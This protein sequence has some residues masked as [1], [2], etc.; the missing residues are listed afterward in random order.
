MKQL[1]ISLLLALFLYGCNSE[2]TQNDYAEDP[3]RKDQW[4]ISGVNSE[5]DIEHINL[6]QTHYSGR[7][8]LIS[9]VDNG[10]DISH[11][12]LKPNIGIGNYSYLPKEYNFEEKS[13][14]GTACAGIIA[15]VEGNGKGIRGIA[16]SA[17]II[18]FNALRLATISNLADAL[19]REKS[20]VWISNNS[21]G[22]I[23]SWGEP[24]ALKKLMEDALIEGVSKGRDGKGI[25]YVF[26]AGNG[27][28]IVND[29]PIDNVNYSGLVNN[30][31]TVPVC[32][33]DEYG[34]RAFYSEKGA[35]LI[36]CAPSKGSVSGRGITTTDVQGKYGYN[37][38]YFKEDYLDQNYTKNF[39]G[40]S[41]SAPIVSGVIGLI[42]EA[43][44]QLT[45]RDI[46][47]V[48]AKSAKKNDARD[49]DWRINSAGYH[50]NHKYGFGLVDTD[51][52]IR[53]ALQHKLLEKEQ[54]FE[55][56][57]NVSMI[58]PDGSNEGISDEISVDND[59]KI[60][61]IDVV[62]DASDH[63]NLGE[64]DVILTSPTGTIS[65]L[66]EQHNTLFDVFV[67]NHWRFGTMRHLGEQAKGIW[68]INVIDKKSGNT[69]TFFKWKLKFY[70]NN[71]DA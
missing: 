6:N 50:V 12:D 70:G 54:I 15:A 14:H 37:P 38:L 9:L 19:I 36:V 67:Y 61:F 10:I 22:D 34:K 45:W 46:R 32:A 49:N 28:N 42:L 68:K 24:L 69:G 66:A 44:P 47:V 27:D 48:L 53:I 59:L 11:E 18:G 60:E 40:T 3:L 5:A 58:I 56:E 26:A 51:E 17:K 21:W 25:I 4:Y 65:I 62:F 35:T 64:L 41:A 29:L 33:V 2:D 13:D 8:V 16:P 63:P 20:R 23:N 57:K 39:G 30:R 55:Y 43:R 71:L 52:A 7:G 1:W 31:Y